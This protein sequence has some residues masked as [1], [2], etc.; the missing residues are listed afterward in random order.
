MTNVEK[1]L[2]DLEEVADVIDPDGVL[3]LDEEG[4][5]PRDYNSFCVIDPESRR[6]CEETPTNEVVLAIRERQ[7]REWIVAWCKTRP[8]WSCQ[9]EWDAK[10]DYSEWT[11]LVYD[12]DGWLGVNDDL[13]FWWQGTSLAEALANTVKAL[14]ELYPEYAA[15][16]E[17]R[18]ATPTHPETYSTA[19]APD[20]APLFPTST[21][22]RKDRNE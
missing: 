15:Q 6:A 13:Q 16:T 8:G 20:D 4:V 18:I 11:V 1:Q 7:A 10:H 5:E 21:E 22:E 9:I 17:E 12:L 19:D 2:A 3:W 14:I